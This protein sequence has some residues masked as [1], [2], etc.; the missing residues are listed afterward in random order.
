MGVENIIKVL[1]K[2]YCLFLVVSQFLVNLNLPNS[3]NT[4]RFIVFFRFGKF[5]RNLK[6]RFLGKT[7]DQV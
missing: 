2:F 4:E 3:I 7:D 1:R 6:I 5:L